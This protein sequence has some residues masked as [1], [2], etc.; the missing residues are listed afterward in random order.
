MTETQDPLAA[1][2]ELTYNM[3]FA[4]VGAPDDA[5][6]VEQADDALAALDTLMA[7]VTR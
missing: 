3:F 4:L 5:E 1:A 6:V 7:A 2:Q